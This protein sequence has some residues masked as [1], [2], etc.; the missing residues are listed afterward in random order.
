MNQ[1]SKTMKVVGSAAVNFQR[2]A[3]GFF[4]F[5]LL[6]HL[7]EMKFNIINRGAANFFVALN[8]NKREYR[9]FIV[10]GGDPKGAFLIR[11]E[12]PSVFP[13]QY[14]KRV[15]SLY[16]HVYTPGYAANFEIGW[17]FKIQLNPAK[18][19]SNELEQVEWLDGSSIQ[20]VSDWFTRPIQVSMIASNKVSPHKD[21]HYRI[22]RQLAKDIDPKIL[23]VYGD[24]WNGSIL[25]KVLHRLKVAIFALRNNTPPNLIEIYGSLF[26]NYRSAYGP[27]RSKHEI[28]KNSQFSL[29][30]ENSRTTVS[31]KLFD[32]ILNGAIPVYVGPRL[33]SVGIPSGVAYEWNLELDALHLFLENIDENTIKSIIAD[34]ISFVKSKTFLEKWTEEEVYKKLASLIN[35]RIVE[36]L[37]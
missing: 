14:Q 37:N 35:Q 9:E 33:S 12:P 13:S 17:P 5:P 16:A 24:L 30:I 4:E 7:E 11:L 19:T 8:H 20:R 10:N 28:L 29:V 27:V 15:E 36:A 6:K 34:G 23:Q 3:D 26:S 1:K 21:N 32:V 25:R 22:R 31:E 18:P 2:G